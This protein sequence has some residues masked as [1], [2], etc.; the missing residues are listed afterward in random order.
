MKIHMKGGLRKWRNKSIIINFYVDRQEKVTTVTFPRTYLSEHKD[1]I[2][3]Q[4]K[5]TRILNILFIYSPAFMFY[6]GSKSIW[7]PF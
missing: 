3:T 7:S 4:H 2:F 6:V 5:K 1:L